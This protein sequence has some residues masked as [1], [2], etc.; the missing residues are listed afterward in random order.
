[1]PERKRTWHRPVTF[2]S[3]FPN[4]WQLKTVSCQLIVFQLASKSKGRKKL[5]SEEL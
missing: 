4:R 3:T 1:M 2:Y 5:Y